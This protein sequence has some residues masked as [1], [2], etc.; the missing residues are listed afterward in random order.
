MSQTRIH[1]KACGGEMAK[2]AK[3]CPHC[4]AKNKKM[5]IWLIA[6]VV[7]LF[8]A[9]V[10]SADG[11]EST[12]G[13]TNSTIGNDKGVFS[14]DCGITATAEMGTDII[15]Q[16]TVS[17]SIKNVT[18]KEIVAIQFYA[19]P[20]NVYGEEVTGVFAQ[21]KLYTDEA[22]SA[23]GSNSVQ[24]QL[25]DRE[26]KTV[27]LYVYSVYFRDGSQWGNKDATKSQI[28]KNGLLIQVDGES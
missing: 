3:T 10:G 8:I 2:S 14:G 20:Y 26:V 11:G 9:I 23:G 12:E 7:V 27:Q 28:L 19:V 16:P 17:V 5:P 15:G 13:G 6:L 4:G 1:C 25:L 22:I 21:N 18:D 24:W